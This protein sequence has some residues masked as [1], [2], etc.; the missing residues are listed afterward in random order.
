VHDFYQRTGD[1]N[2]VKPLTEL[3]EIITRQ[4]LHNLAGNRSF[5]RGEDY[6]ENGLVGPITEKTGVISAKVHG[7]H[8]YETRLKIVAAPQGKARLDHAC[9]C[10]IGRDGDFC[11]HC[12]ALGLAWIAKANIVG[13][14]ERATGR[15]SKRTS[16]PHKEISLKDIRT[17]LEGQGSKLILD[18]L[19]DQVKTE[20]RLRENLTLKIAKENA[21]GIDITAY[22]RAIQSAFHTSGFIHYNDMYEYADGIGEAIDSIERLLKEGFAQEA[23]PLCEYAFEQAASAIG[24]M[25]D[26]DGHFG[27][28]CE[29]LGRLHLAACKAAKPDPVELAKRL[30]D[31]E[32]MDSDLDLFYNAPQVYKTILGKPGLV[33]YRRL[34]EKE[35]SRVEEKEPGSR[36]TGYSGKRRRITSIME[37]LAK[38]DGDVDALIAVK[39]RGLSHP[40]SYLGIAEICKEAGRRNE[41]LGWAEKGLSS[42]PKNQDNRLR[43]FV[44]GEYHRR[45]RYDEAYGLYWIQFAERSG[46]EEY[47]KLMEYSRKIER[48]EPARE[49]ALA[50]LRKEIEGEK[51]NPNVR[52]WHV[53]P[54]HSRLVEIFLWEK[55]GDAAWTEALVGG[56]SDRLWLELA[57]LREK[58]HPADA[59]DVYKR[60]VD[61]VIEQKNDEAYTEAFR[62]VGKIYELMGRLGK[63]AEFQSYLANL[64]LRHKP[65]RNL[66]KLLDKL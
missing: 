63:P 48:V 8:T 45:K 24:D 18:M 14:E 30:F 54:D 56:C 60:L 13:A 64:R 1:I 58:E 19:M 51:E 49:D 33:E 23:I 61:P 41:A 46:L 57:R 26:S 66:M 10:P 11:K 7:S 25:D 2:E 21:G 39:K 15:T 32:M 6:F 35:W 53:K 9:T 4:N 22:R 42:F 3:K 28:I 50:H 12:V 59:V 55:D 62:M 17:W 36:D 65:K 31:F 29:R 27:D 43:D 16:A 47:K 38:A 5:G 34:A 44:A 40:Y 20:S 37:S 52:Y